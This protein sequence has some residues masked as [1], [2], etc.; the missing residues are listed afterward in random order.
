MRHVIAG[1]CSLGV[2]I[3][4]GLGFLHVIAASAW[5][6]P[7]ACKHLVASGNPEYP[8]FL[9]RDPDDEN[10]LVGA[11]ADMMQWLA[12]ELGVTIEIKYGGPWARVQEE[13]KA[14]HIDLIAGAFY[15]LPRLEYMDY[16][17]PPFRETKTSIWARNEA[18]FPYKKW[19]D[20]KGLQGVT[21]INNSF[22]EEFD[23]YA[24]QS[25]KIKSVASLEQALKMLQLGHVNYLIYEED[26][27]LAYAAKMDI[28]DVKTL[29]VPVTNEQLY[30]TLSHKSACNTGEMRGLLA[31]A[32]YTLAKQ[33]GMKDMIDA[34]IQRWRKQGK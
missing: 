27:G 24:K 19:S 33:N 10:R 22:G 9:W 23:K 16:V 30:L 5:A 17:Y 7:D 29:S 8:P 21:V 26:P 13:V 18:K 34:N 6:L 11:N 14:G 20:L 1:I 2:R 31:K 32:M 3:G 15:T 28:N 12:K 25:L 4:A